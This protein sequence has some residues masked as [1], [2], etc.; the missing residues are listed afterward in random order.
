[1]FSFANGSFNSSRTESIDSGLIIVNIGDERPYVR[2]EMK[3]AALLVARATRVWRHRPC[4]L[5]R[6]RGVTRRE[7]PWTSGRANISCAHGEA[8]G[9]QRL[10]DNSQVGK[11]A[12]CA[13]C[14]SR[15]LARTRS[16][17]IFVEKNNYYFLKLFSQ[18]KAAVA[19][20][21]AAGPPLPPVIVRRPSSV[22]RR[23]PLVFY[24][25]G[26]MIGWGSTWRPWNSP[27]N[28]KPSP[29]RF[30]AANLPA[31]GLFR[32]A[33]KGVYCRASERTR[34]GYFRS[35]CYSLVH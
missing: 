27:F 4:S 3:S 31:F 22:A 11:L 7:T 14:S 35:S 23:P 30:S 6:V 1:M 26:R 20:G 28:N 24:R 16:R 8:P 34:L 10:Q 9:A 19:E 13:S 2:L 33:K 17:P 12:F 25:G 18:W 29:G 32:D 15:I 5:P 21:D